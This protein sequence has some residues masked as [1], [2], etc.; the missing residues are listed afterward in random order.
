MRDP[1]HQEGEIRCELDFHFDTPKDRKKLTARRS[2]H[3]TEI[4]LLRARL[5]IP[6]FAGKMYLILGPD[7]YDAFGVGGGGAF[8][9]TPAEVIDMIRIDGGAFPR[10][11]G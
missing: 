7:S 10:Q 8:E 5:S 9:T 1:I 4:S 2:N 6:I 3:Q 11:W